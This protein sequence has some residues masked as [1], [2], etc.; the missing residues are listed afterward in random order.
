MTTALRTL[1]LAAMACAA[2]AQP[3]FAAQLTTP[4]YD[5]HGD[6]FAQCRLGYFGGKRDLP[7][8]VTLVGHADLAAGW[9]VRSIRTFK[10]GPA[11]RG[12]AVGKS[13]SPSGGDLSCERVR[14]VFEVPN[15]VR[16]SDFVGNVCSLT[17]GLDGK[18]C[19]V[20]K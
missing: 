10:M 14:C 4:I 16:K 20:A 6:D 9:Q 7:V 8:K 5:T 18:Y 15:T 17:A 13:C 1:A 3:A 19:E 2:M 11:N 12:V